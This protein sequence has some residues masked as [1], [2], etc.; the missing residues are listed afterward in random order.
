MVSRVITGGTVPSS[1]LSVGSVQACHLRVVLSRGRTLSGGRLRPV[2][3]RGSGR[4]LDNA[5]AGRAPGPRYEVAAAFVPA[6]RLIG[7][8]ERPGRR[9]GPGGTSAVHGPGAAPPARSWRRWARRRGRR[10]AAALSRKVVRRRFRVSVEAGVPGPLRRTGCSAG[11][12]APVPWIGCSSSGRRR[13][14]APCDPSSA[15]Q[16][17]RAGRGA[18]G[19]DEAPHDAGVSSGRSGC[20]GAA[21]GFRPARRSS[22]ALPL[23]APGAGASSPRTPAVPLVELV[24]DRRRNEA[25]G[26]SGW[27]SQPGRGSRV[28]RL[29][30]TELFDAPVLAAGAG[31]DE[32]RCPAHHVRIR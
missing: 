24:L 9:C 11:P 7:E 6:R 12:V 23:H 3:P 8:V 16:P 17:V 25:S 21:A 5:A 26:C 22:P 18:D 15:V 19:V 27:S 4:G 20:I 31:S 13:L 30:G 28:L 2:P 32:A 29:G 14:V 10:R 1:D